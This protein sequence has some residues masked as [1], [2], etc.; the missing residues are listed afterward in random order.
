MK[1]KNK[2]IS[3]ILAIAMVIT[4]LMPA[5]ALTAMAAEGNTAI[6][7]PNVLWFGRKINECVY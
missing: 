7:L 4:S 3:L 1:K 2:W 5:T 6:D